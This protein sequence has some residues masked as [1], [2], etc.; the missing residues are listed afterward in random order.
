MQGTIHNGKVEEIND[1]TNNG[2]SHYQKRVCTNEDIKYDSPELLKRALKI[3]GIYPGKDWAKGYE[4]Y[5]SKRHREK[6]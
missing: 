1:L 6:Y 2:D 4:L 3:G 5:A